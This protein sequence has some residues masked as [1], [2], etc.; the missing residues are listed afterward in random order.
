VLALGAA[1]LTLWFT[2]TGV[3][4]TTDSATYLSAADNLA[5]GHGAT[6]AFAS[7]TTR[8]TPAQQVSFGHQVPMTSYPPLYSL[9]LSAPDAAGLSRSGAVR[10][11]NALCLGALVAL[12]GLALWWLLR[13]PVVTLVV[14][15]LLVVSGPTIRSFTGAWNP[16]GLATFALSEALFLPLCLLALLAGAHAATRT[17][18]RSV[19]IAAALVGGAT[20]TRYVG[21]S[22]G[23]ATGA[24]ILL[25]GTGRPG[26][27]AVRAALVAAAG[28][29]AVVGWG[30]LSY[31]LWGGDSPKTMAWHP[32][33]VQAHL[34]VDVAGAWFH[35]PPA[36]PWAARGALV[37]VLVI[38]PAAAMLAPAVL[39]WLR[40]GSSSL[41]GALLVTLGA[42][43]LAY[44]AALALTQAFLD[45]S[46]APNQRLLAPVQLASYLLLAAVVALAGDRL[47]ARRWPSMR[48]GCALV[49]ALATAAV[50]Q[51][52]FRLN[53]LANAMHRSAV[54]TR[55]QAATDPLRSLPRGLVMFSDTPSGLWLYSGQ[56]SYRLPTKVVLTTGRTDRTYGEE[57]RQTEAIVQRRGGLIVVSSDAS[58]AEYIS[59]AALRT[60][61]TC[62]TGEILLAVP[63][64]KAASAAARACPRPPAPAPVATLKSALRTVRAWGTPR[65]NPAHRAR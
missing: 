40:P 17:D 24:A 20:L 38:A 65:A 29:V 3:G 1:A 50:V 53:T 28:I 16:L 13:P 36:W 11:V 31:S 54:A 60:V 56:A 58:A 37:L 18:G 35:L 23:V 15:G 8:Y 62:R 14:L 49:V 7:E 4:L 5:D 42:F 45:A 19:V 51:P 10:V 22:T 30:L 26:R 25:V 9:A 41:A 47:A 52:L 39:G 34:A 21:A 2:S 63:G 32:G 12:V 27:R 48:L 6:T 57:V 44:L 64:T 55:T 61:G 46:T 59:D 43:V 33:N